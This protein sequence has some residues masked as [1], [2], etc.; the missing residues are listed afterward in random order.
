MDFLSPQNDPSR[1]NLIIAIAVS[2]LILF[3]FE[4]YARMIAPPPPAIEKTAGAEEKMADTNENGAPGAPQMAGE[5]N[6]GTP[7]MATTAAAQAPVDIEGSD[8]T[9][10]FDLSGGKIN[11]LLLTRYRHEKTGEPIHLLQ[12]AGGDKARYFETG[13]LSREVA[14]PTGK[15]RWQAKGEEAGEALSPANPLILTWENG[16]GQVFTRTITLERNNYTFV[17]ADEVRNSGTTPVTLA[18]YAQNLITGADFDASTFYLFQGPEGMVDDLKVEADYEDLLKTPVTKEG[19]TGWAGVSDRYFLSAVIPPQNVAHTW[20]FQHAKA[21]GRDWF[22]TSVQGEAAALQPGET[23]VHTWRLYA[24]PKVIEI[25]ERQGANLDRAVDYGWFDFIARPL[26]HLLE[27]FHEHVGNW[28]YAIILV[29]ILLKILLYPL[30]GRSYK[31]MSKMKKLQPK[32]EQLKEQYGDDREQFAIKM[33]NLYKEEKVNPASGCWPVLMQ[34]PI[35]FA[36]YKVIF[37]SIEFRDA[38]FI[39][40]ITDLSAADPFYV[41]PILMGAS[42]WFQMRL[43]PPAPDPMQQKILM[44]M[45]IIF[46]FMF[47]SFPSGLVLYWLVNNVLSIGQQWWMMRKMA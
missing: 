46:T 14:V 31:A 24:G 19:R 47:L 8:L 13:W 6:A 23:L 37:L 34:I 21:G 36:F 39:L 33:M 2:A 27:W 26:F 40:W 44:A 11:N 30:A 10:H 18:P 25:L 9:G 7:A 15:T 45:P 20:R 5:S 4:F 29:T 17:V 41:L 22:T 16:N 3:G 38:P 28:G 1:R 35:F 32:M 43:N 12:P 42:M